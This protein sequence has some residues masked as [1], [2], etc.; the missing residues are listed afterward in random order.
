MTDQRLVVAG[1][2][3]HTD[4]HHAAVVDAQGRL[5]ATAAF[6]TTANGYE[7]LIRWLR[8]QGKIERVGVESTGAYAA[9]RKSTR[10][11]SSHIQKSR[12]PSSA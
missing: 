10:L 5:L 9:D 8:E 4:E 11:N 7:Q 3:A 1:V 6:P 2:D 12:M